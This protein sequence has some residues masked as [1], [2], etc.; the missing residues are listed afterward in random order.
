M[1]ALTK[2]WLA[3]GAI[4]G[5]MFARLVDSCNIGFKPETIRIGA[6]QGTRELRFKDARSLR[7]L[8][9]EPHLRHARLIGAGGESIA[10]ANYAGQPINQLLWE[11]PQPPADLSLIEAV[12]D[13]P[14]FRAAYLC[15]G[16]D[17]FWQSEDSLNAYEVHGRDHAHLPKVRGGG[18]FPGQDETID[19]RENPGRERP[20]G[21]ILLLAASMMWFGP[22]AF[23]VL[24]RGRLLGITD[25]SVVERANGTVRVELFPFDWYTDS[26]SDLRHVQAR[27][28]DAMRFDELESRAEEFRPEIDPTFEITSDGCVHGGA[29]RVIEW[30]DE[31]GKVA[32]PQSNAARVRIT[33]LS[34]TGEVLHRTEMPAQA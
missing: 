27:F 16:D 3:D 28:S 32:T 11:L 17:V 12:T 1:R 21:G 29:R 4:D 22:P 7:I 8:A 34:G 33:E 6:S 9:E 2:M 30:L 18:F 25:G 13:L 10:L 31:T 14:G 24:D 15:D 23:E 19:V 26:V 20:V 5:P